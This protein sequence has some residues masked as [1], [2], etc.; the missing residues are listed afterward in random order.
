M[1]R[2]EK[3]EALQRKIR[4]DDVSEL[5]VPTWMLVRDAIKA[6]RVD[7]ALEL[8][9]YELDRDCAAIDS[10]TLGRDM[11]LTRL[12]RFGEEEIEKFHRERYSPSVIDWLSTTP[13]VEESLRRF[14]EIFRVFTPNLF[15]TEEVDRYVM[16]MDPCGTGGR[17]RRMRSVGT[18]QKA[19][20]W[21]WSKSG[22][23][24]YCTHCSVFQEIL[25]IEMRGYPICVTQY[26]DNPQDP[27]IHF[28]YKKPELIPDE[29]FIRIGKSPWRK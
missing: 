20:P 10:L 2:L 23:C 17:L 11:L 26:P 7:E 9:D 6:G 25:P 27:C 12:G 4:K 18:T 3:S 15:V 5:G 16:K 24:Y 8:I 13:G 28:Y 22:V 21:S 1:I 29:Y 19:Y 14:T